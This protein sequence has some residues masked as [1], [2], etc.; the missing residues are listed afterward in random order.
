MSFGPIDLNSDGYIDWKETNLCNQGLNKDRNGDGVISSSEF[1]Q[2][3]VD[4]TAA[5]YASFDGTPSKTFADYMLRKAQNFDGNLSN[6]DALN[7]IK[8]FDVANTLGAIANDGTLTA[9]QVRALELLYNRDFDGNGQIGVASG[10]ANVNALANAWAAGP[11]T[12]DLDGNGTISAWEQQMFTKLHN[13]DRN[14]DGTVTPQEQ[15]EN[16]EALK[17]TAAMF[18]TQ[19]GNDPAKLAKAQAMA[20]D[21]LFDRF[22]GAGGSTSGNI[23]VNTT[24]TNRSDIIA[25]VNNGY[26]DIHDYRL[27]KAAGTNL[28]M[29][30]SEAMTA[31]DKFNFNGG[32]TLD[33]GEL[34]ALET[35]FSVDIDNN[36]QIGDVGNNTTMTRN[37]AAQ[38]LRNLY[39]NGNTGGGVSN[40]VS[41][42]DGDGTVS[43]WETNLFTLYGNKDLN[44]DGNVTQAEKDQ[45]LAY[46]KQLGMSGLNVDGKKLAEKGFMDDRNGDG[47]ITQAEIAANIADISDA[48]DLGYDGTTGNTLA[49]YRADKVAGFDGAM[50]IADAQAIVNQ[51]NN[52]GGT[53][54]GWMDKKELE[55]LETFLGLDLDNNGTVG[56]SNLTNQTLQALSLN[57]WAGR[58]STKY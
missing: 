57:F 14:S 38:T 8:A 51:F 20:L 32:N 13:T 25:A 21:G 54:N 4:V 34:E 35:Y 39:N 33:S 15:A 36:G 43:P 22:G 7:A 30:S 48:Q 55:R 42:L 27:D 23:T 31:V 52:N 46:L 40:G 19:F 10:T 45:N 41:D 5:F 53:T 1:Q 17:K 47:V 3:L 6:T 18:N 11:V 49:D 16:F 58:V 2:N 24:D 12:A 9:A 28:N 29:S 37:Q 44:N 26:T 56:T 50:S